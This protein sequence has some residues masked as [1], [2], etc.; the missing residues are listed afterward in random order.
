MYLEECKKII[1]E[2]LKAP[3]FGFAPGP[4]D[5]RTGPAWATCSSPM[6]G[7]YIS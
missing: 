4:C 7:G 2:A 1:D 3:I 5:L 6:R